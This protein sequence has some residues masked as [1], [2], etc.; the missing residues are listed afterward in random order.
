MT[1]VKRPKIAIYDFT[2]CEG[3]EVVIISLKEKLLAIE[4][5][6]DIID[7]RFIQQ[8]KEKGPFFATII[9]GSPI[10]QREINT[11][12][13]LRENSQ[14]IFALGAC[15]SLAGIPGILKKEEREKWCRKIYGQNYKPGCIDALPLGAYVKVDFSIHGCPVNADEVVRI[16]EEILAGKQPSY[17]GYSV[18]FD[19]KIAGN[20][21]RIIEEKPCLGPITQGGCGAICVSGGSACYGCFGLRCEANIEGLLLALDKFANKKEVDRYFSMF[22]RQ[23]PEYQNIVKPLTN[24]LKH[25]QK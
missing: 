10:T 4:K 11:L 7:W 9:E 15:A 25:D 22:L 13:Y 12:K 2:D 20:P 18:C 16:F 14:Y 17:R 3:C 1:N 8:K 21:C 5:R 24:K 6:F 23:T 19:C